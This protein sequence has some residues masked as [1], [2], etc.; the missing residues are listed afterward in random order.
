M[1]LRF[2]PKMENHYKA[3]QIIETENTPTKHNYC[4]GP[5]LY[6]Q[7]YHRDPESKETT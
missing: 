2:H 4:P 1:Q 3:E 5:L 7:T 6:Q